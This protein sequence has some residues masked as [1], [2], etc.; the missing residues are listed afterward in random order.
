MIKVVLLLPPLIAHTP[1]VAGAALFPHLNYA[2]KSLDTRLTSPQ[3][4]HLLFSTNI[5]PVLRK[6]TKDR[7]RKSLLLYV[8]RLVQLGG[9]WNKSLWWWS[10][11]AAGWCI[12][13]QHK[14]TSTSNMVCCMN[15]TS[16]TVFVR[17]PSCLVQCSSLRCR[18]KQSMPR[19]LPKASDKQKIHL[20]GNLIFVPLNSL[21]VHVYACSDVYMFIKS[22]GLLCAVQHTVTACIRLC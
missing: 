3:Y 6:H 12:Y 8:G 9:D 1:S 15:I 11:P 7:S 21:H 17:F 10:K 19:T 22:I 5:W 14:W 4:G 18:Q 13:V 16:C 20:T 2:R